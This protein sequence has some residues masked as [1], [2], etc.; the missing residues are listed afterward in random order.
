MEQS[1]LKAYPVL[2]VC[3]GYLS[4]TQLFQQIAMEWQ[5]EIFMRELVMEEV[6]GVS[7]GTDSCSDLRD[8][9]SSTIAADGALVGIVA[10]TVIGGPIGAAIAGAT[11]ILGG[12]IGEVVG[13]EIEN[14]CE[15]SLKQ[16]EG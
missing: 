9:A 2:A 6:I 11:V 14:A 12:L 1:I 8:K 5:K 13:S 3:I 4:N 7:G 16:K 15:E 10:G